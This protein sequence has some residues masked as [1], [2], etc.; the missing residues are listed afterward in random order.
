M[1]F[2]IWR[3][4][5]SFSV[6][7]RTTRGQNMKFLIYA[8][9]TQGSPLLICL[10]TGIIDSLKPPRADG[11]G[12][13]ITPHFPNMAALRCFLG[14]LR[15]TTGYLGSAGFLYFDLF[16]VMIMVSNT[17]FMGSVCRILSRG[18]DNQTRLTRSE[19]QSG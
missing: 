11:Q 13:A 14:E 3:T 16:L 9:Y 15:N 5:A 2:D 12:S 19:S 10:A 1:G 4:F 8:L 7:L 17:F 6:R 18:W